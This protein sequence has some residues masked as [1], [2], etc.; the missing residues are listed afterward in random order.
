MI[1]A[2]HFIL[3]L[4]SMMYNQP[5]NSYN[6]NFI[7]NLRSIREYA[8]AASLWAI[9]EKLAGSGSLLSTHSEVYLADRSTKKLVKCLRN[10]PLH[11]HSYLT[12]N[13]LV[14]GHSCWGEIRICSKSHD[15]LN[16]WRALLPVSLRRL[17]D[18]TSHPHSNLSQKIFPGAVLHVLHEPPFQSHGNISLLSHFYSLW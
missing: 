14:T 5:L 13:T 6:L 18:Q 1:F 12:K 3:I 7:G 17:S 8:N 10:D 9:K 16:I 2:F 11:L 4:C 15:M